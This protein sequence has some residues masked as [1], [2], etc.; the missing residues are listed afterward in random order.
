MTESLEAVAAKLAAMPDG[1]RAEVVASALRLAG[2]FRWTPIVGPQLEAFFC[3]ADLLYYGGQ[4]GGGKS[5]LLTGLAL[6][7][8]R[9]SLLVRRQYTDLSAL[10]DYTLEVY[11]SRRGYNGASPPRLTTDDDRVIDFGACARPGDE[12]GWQGRPHDF[13]GI[14]E[15]CQ[16]QEGQVRYLMG[17]VRT[18]TPGQRCRIVFASN[19]PLTAE[20]EW[21]TRMFAP[22]LDKQHPN[23]AAPGELRW[24]AT[25]ENGKDMEVDGPEPV[26]IDGKMV[27]PLSRT[28]ISAKV[29]DNPYLMAAGYQRTLDALPEPLRSAIRDGDFETAIE[30]SEF[31][32]VPTSWVKAA[33]ER[34][35]PYPPAGVGM[36]SMGVDPAGGGRDETVV[37]M[38]Y[39]GWFD[40][41][42]AVPGRE[43]P[44]GSDVAG[45]VIAKRRHNCP[46]VIDMGGGYGSGVFEHLQSNG[47]LVHSHKGAER[48]H[49]KAKDRKLG[50][51]N[52]RSESWW[53]FREALDPDQPGG[54]QITLPQDTTLLADLASTKFTTTTVAGRLVIQ[55]EP[56]TDVVGRLGRS[57]DRGDAVVMAFTRGQAGGGWQAPD[58]SLREI[59]V[60]HGYESRKRYLRH[61]D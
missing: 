22:W 1:E 5:S 9:S 34:W 36:S 45:L 19:P 43:T 10:I 25:D 29:T 44:L 11:G 4:G 16:L 30:D 47:V 50:F 53:M 2:A 57:P 46:V 52:K 24:F 33:Q 32:I 35:V 58:P 14:D 8:H 17:W 60:I 48:S 27:E 59:K 61:L 12:T 40:K 26:E 31:Q 55:A 37:A 15:A 7:A 56:K 39:G 41:M 38:R 51:S 20:G 28:F 13:L 3:L 21:L 49:A 42:I 23:P 6:T 18:V 54:S